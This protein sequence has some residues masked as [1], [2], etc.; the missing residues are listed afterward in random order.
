MIILAWWTYRS[1]SERI[2]RRAALRGMSSFTRDSGEITPSTIT[3][4]SSIV[5]EEH[6]HSLR[7]KT[8]MQVRTVYVM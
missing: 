6:D 8:S 7:R 1:Q 3:Q 5:V 4:I 2:L